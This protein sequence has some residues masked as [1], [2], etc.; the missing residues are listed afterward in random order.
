[1]KLLVALILAIPTYGISLAILILYLVIKTRNTKKDISKAIVFLSEKHEGESICFDEINYIQARAYVE[2]FGEIKKEIGLYLELLISIEGDSYRVCL[3]K[4]PIGKGAIFKVENISW[5]IRLRDWLDQ[6]MRSSDLPEPW[7]IRSLKNVVLGSG[8]NPEFYLHVRFKRLPPE[9]CELCNLE[10]LYLQ[11]AGLVELP[12]NIGKLQR[13]KNLKLGGNRLKTL[14][15]SIGR[16]QSLEVLTVWLNE[17]E[18]VPAE[19]GM[20]K[21]LRG[22]SFWENP[23]ARLPDEIV[24]LTNLKELEIY[25]MPNLKLTDSQIEWLVALKENGCEI[26]A[27]D[28]V[29]RILASPLDIS[30]RL[31]DHPLGK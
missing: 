25:F 11:N 23:L 7:N 10:N 1:M 18:S 21:N 14:P 13:L 5:M 22:L 19:I 31:I 24:E 16:L 20:L 30:P 2:E 12:Y 4:E 3:N 15:A 8:V 29:E 27:D 28:E 9:I 26:L 6:Y 17:L